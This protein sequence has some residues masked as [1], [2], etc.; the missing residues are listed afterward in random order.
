MAK[1]KNTP[2]A[3]A[4][5]VALSAVEPVRIDGVDVAPGEVFEAKPADAEALLAAG[6]ARPADVG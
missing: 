1:A 2:V 4:E 6:A 5:M 3:P